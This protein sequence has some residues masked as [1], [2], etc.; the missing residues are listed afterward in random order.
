MFRILNQ[1]LNDKSG[2]TTIEY[3]VIAAYI[4]VAIANNL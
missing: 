2:V 3:G 4:A 1:C